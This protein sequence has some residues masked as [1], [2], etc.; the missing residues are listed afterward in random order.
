MLYI[1]TGDAAVGTNPQNLKSLGGKVL[2]IRSDG[3]IPKTNPFYKRGGNARYMWTY[4]HRNVQGLTFRPSNGQMWSA[5]HGPSRDDEVN[6]ILKGRNYGWAPDRRP[7]TT[8]PDP[9]TDKTR[10]PKAYARSGSSGSSD[11]G[12]QRGDL[13][14][15][16]AVE[17]L[18][19]Q[20]A[21][22]QAARARA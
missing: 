16:S 5:E 7:T 19:R 9:M 17:V 11:G 21:R 18:E 22:G 14:D 6:R 12:H 1:G 8:R 13:P 2:R 15:R 20:A 10:F 3:S 4:G